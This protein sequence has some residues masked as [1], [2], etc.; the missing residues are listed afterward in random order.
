[1]FIGFKYD[2]LRAVDNIL[3]LVEVTDFVWRAACASVGH[4]YQ[5]SIVSIALFTVCVTPLK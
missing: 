5:R 4:H 2:S 1:M 3:V